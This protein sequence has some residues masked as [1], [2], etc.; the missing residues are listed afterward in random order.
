MDVLT[1]DRMEQ[2]KCITKTEQCIHLIE[3][4][5]EDIYGNPYCIRC[6]DSED[7]LCCGCC[8]EMVKRK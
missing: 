2:C 3:K 1:K 8:R 6:C 5:M 4:W 7:T